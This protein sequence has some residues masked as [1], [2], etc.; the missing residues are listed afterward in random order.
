MTAAAPGGA[1]QIVR[2]VFSDFRAAWRSL[3]VTDL[4]YKA[5]AFAILTPGTMCAL[6]WLAARSG[7]EVV[8]DVDIARFFFATWTGWF[9][10]IIGGSVLAAITILETACLMGVAASASKGAPLIPRAAL[11]FGA[12][13]AA[14]V[15][16]LAGN[17]VLRVV[18]VLLP[19]VLAAGV[20]WFLLLRAHDIN[21]YLSEKPPQFW[22]AAGIGAVLGACLAVLVVRTAVR[23]ALALPLILF[24]GTHPRRALAE[25]AQRSTGI[26][27]LILIVLAG[28]GA[29]A[30]LVATAVNAG[31]SA[32]M[33]GLAPGFSGSLPGLLSFIG[34][35]ALVWGIVSLAVAVTNHAVF[36]ALFTRL[37][38]HAASPRDPRIPVASPSDR[39]ALRLS[40][41]A[42]AGIGAII[43]LAIAGVATL[44]FLVSRG[45]RQVVVLAHRGSSATAPENTLAAFR[46]AAEQGADYFELDVQESSDGVVVVVHDRDLMKIGASPMKIW[47]HTADALRTVDIGGRIGPQFSQERVPTLAEALA[48]AKGRCKVV[49]ELKSY[50]HNQ[51][52]EEKVAEIVEAAGM[53][54][55]CIYMS[56]DHDMVRRMKELRPGWRC[57]VLAAK[58]MGDLT[59][60]KADFL[61]VEARVATGPFV[62]RAHRARQDV[63]VWT[64]NDPAWM[65][66][67]IGF[68]VD[69]L[70]TDKPDVARIVVGRHAGMSD[71]QRVLVALLVRLGARTDA[72]QAEDALRP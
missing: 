40:G 33:R 23:W 68:G 26:R 36:A 20:T 22:V 10:L 54:D 69:G 39:E 3:V 43:L 8:A 57:G 7:N 1:R 48:V 34:V 21:W 58:A 42:W 2:G 66:T 63:Y 64:V 32:M 70:I 27:R 25:S 14:P 53:Q 24:E 9:V 35:M 45:Q 51:H 49:V 56:L 61:A 31:L 37:Y 46:L 62:R 29:L 28:W 18:A 65:L 12:A 38:L 55:S 72:L 15:F 30:L 5:L 11:R 16:R 4:A 71:A 44:V 41:R 52:L 47:E 59:T 60:L 19:F 6:R 50:G 67:A 13:S 17:A